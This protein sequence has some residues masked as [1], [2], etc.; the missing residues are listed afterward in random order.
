ML[1]SPL[2]TLFLRTSKA[3]PTSPANI[4][5]VEP[6]KNQTSNHAIEECIDYSDD[7]ITQGTCGTIAGINRGEKLQECE[8]IPWPN[9][10]RY[11]HEKYGTSP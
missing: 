6:S 11:A 3:L 9:E 8:T 4:R 1:E 10:V 7:Q 2:E 5:I